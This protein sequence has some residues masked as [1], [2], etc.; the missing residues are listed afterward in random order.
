MTIYIVVLFYNF[1]HL[2]EKRTFKI[3]S[4]RLFELNNYYSNLQQNTNTDV[5]VPTYDRARFI[6]NR[7]SEKI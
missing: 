7:V 2:E 5:I 6:S 1:D 3:F 4:K